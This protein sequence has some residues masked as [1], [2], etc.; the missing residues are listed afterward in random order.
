[1]QCSCNSQHMSSP[2]QSC[3]CMWAGDHM[4]THI[5]PAAVY[6][7]GVPGSAHVQRVLLQFCGH[8]WLEQA[9]KQP[10]CMAMCP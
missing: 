4:N 5:Q 8:H 3:M 1:L 7:C 9:A 10:G 2:Q 6:L